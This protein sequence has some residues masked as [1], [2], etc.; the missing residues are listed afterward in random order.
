MG[1]L[2][3]RVLICLSLSCLLDCELLYPE[4]LHFSY[5]LCHNSL[6]RACLARGMYLNMFIE[7]VDITGENK[8]C[9]TKRQVKEMIMMMILTANT[10]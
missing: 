4:T 9:I 10:F 3:G 1:L 7:I 5:S 2:A 8:K 6:C